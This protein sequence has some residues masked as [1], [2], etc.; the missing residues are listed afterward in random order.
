MLSNSDVRAPESTLLKAQSASYVLT[1]AHTFRLIPESSL[2]GSAASALQMTLPLFAQLLES[3]EQ[4][5][6]PLDFLHKMMSLDCDGSITGMLPTSVLYYDIEGDGGG[7]DS[8]SSQ[9]DAKMHAFF[10]GKLLR[11]L[12]RKPDL[13]TGKSKIRL[14]GPDC[15]YVTRTN[16][17]NLVKVC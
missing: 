14:V 9:G 5:Y 11:L 12:K 2:L 15:F 6:L 13:S 8:G 10:H 7:F 3:D 4:L 16:C 17:L 1:M